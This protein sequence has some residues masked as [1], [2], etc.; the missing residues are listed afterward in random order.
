MSSTLDS[1]SSHPLV[2]RGFFLALKTLQHSYCF[3]KTSLCT[4]QLCNMKNLSGS[5]NEIDLNECY[6]LLSN[7][8][9]SRLHSPRFSD[10]IQRVPWNMHMCLVSSRDSDS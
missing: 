3:R 6:V 7:V 2:C 5:E 4:D 1:F 10:I 9:G 8:V